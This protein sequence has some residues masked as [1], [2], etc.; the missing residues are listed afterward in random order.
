VPFREV[1]EDCRAVVAN[2]RQLDPLLLESFFGVLQ[3]D[4]LRFAIRSP[5]GGAE[6]E[7]NRSVCSF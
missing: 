5:I 6:E 4:E 3:L 7:E 1:F 2:R